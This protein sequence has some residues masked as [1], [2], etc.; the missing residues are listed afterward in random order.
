MSFNVPWFLCMNLLNNL[1][2]KGTKI[3]VII[4]A[5]TI[6]CLLFL[7]SW[8]RQA[9]FSPYIV[10]RRFPSLIYHPRQ[11]IIIKN[12]R[13]PFSW[14]HHAWH[15]SS[16]THALPTSFVY[17]PILLFWF[18]VNFFFFNGECAQAYI[19]IPT[20]KSPRKTSLS[21][22]HLTFLINFALSFTILP[23]TADVCICLQT[24]HTCMHP[25][26]HTAC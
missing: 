10:T 17:W 2:P 13:K 15:Y 4:I 1:C 18:M 19:W 26:V 11:K 16:S 8:S 20:F 22:T 24:Q 5:I 3:D 14:S 21:T 12:N 9:H 25:G 6:N 7:P 23:L